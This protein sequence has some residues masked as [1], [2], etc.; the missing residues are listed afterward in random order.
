MTIEEIKALDADGVTA[1][2]EEIRSAMNE[3]GADIEALT[4][5]V[6]ALN[7]RKEELRAS[8]QAFQNLRS[9]LGN[10]PVI[11]NAPKE[12][13]VMKT[14]DEVRS[15]P[16]YVSAFA[17]YVKTG[18]DEEVRSILTEQ[19]GVSST[20]KIPVPTIVDTT[21]QHAWDNMPILSLVTKTN[22]KGVVKV[23]VETAADDASVH[24]EGTDAPAEEKVTLKIVTMN[25]ETIKKWV[26]FSDETLD[27]DDGSFLQ[28][29]YNEL[30][31]KVL[32]KAEDTV[33]SDIVTDKDSLNVVVAPTGTVT[34]F[35]TAASKLSDEAQ[36]PVVIINKE[37][38]AYFKG[39][40][41]AANYA[42]DPFDGMT[43][44][45]NNTLKPF[46]SGELT[47]GNYGIVGDLTAEQVNF[48]NGDAV[49]MK[50][51]DL[52]LAEKDLV[53][54]VGRLPMGHGVKGFKRFAVLKKASAH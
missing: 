46:T 31:Y 51:D 10:A 15:M 21:I 45:Y 39:L 23:G 35:I 54:V 25:P 8:A 4:A 18:K 9:K 40:A 26:T 24:A 28:Y 38:E 36:N 29:V 16:E 11:E 7:A 49:Q 53:K 34:D 44:L 30:T 12:K 6:D 50:Y 33:V 3:E 52:S 5:E 17:H 42:I 14:I 43:V 48:P 47:D 2:V 20:A 37:S 22:L 27:T 32:H 13:K 19:A 1:R 41:I